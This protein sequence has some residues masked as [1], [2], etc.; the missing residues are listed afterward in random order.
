MIDAL[1]LRERFHERF[2]GESRLFH[3]PGRVNLIGEHTDYNEGFVLP[4]AID[5][6]TLVAARARDDARLRVH[7][8]NQDETVEVDLAAPGTPRRGAWIDYVEGV[9]RVL[10]E[11][12][13]PV[14]GADLVLESDVPVGAGLSSSAALEISTG[15]ALTALSGTALD[16]VALA[17]AGQAAEHQWVGTQCGIM[18]QLVATSGRR[19]H[20]L[21]IDCRS[22][23][24]HPVPLDLHGVAV[25][26][27]DSGVKHQLAGSEYNTRRRECARGVELLRAVLP[28]IRSLRDV[29]AEHLARAEGVLPEPIRRRCRHVVHENGRTL[30]A[31]EAFAASDFDAAGRLMAGSHRSLRDDYEV[32]SPELDTLVDLAGALPGVVGAR[33]TGGGFGGSTVNLVRR[34]SLDAF[35][36]AIDDGYRRA[37]GTAASLYVVEA[38]AGAREI[39]AAEGAR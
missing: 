27:V 13:L 32:S 20:A 1:R 38:S 29:D 35:G 30:A 18:D 37:H 22:L 28:G 10:M 36:P 12:G 33:M 5:R 21:L 31:A 17:L 25:V 4:M 7:S 2:G 15:L 6:G 23:A 19:G 11:R 9:A 16:P 8:V 34:E 39:A 26:V 14:G 3:A 24:A